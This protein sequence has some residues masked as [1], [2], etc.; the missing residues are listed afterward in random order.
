MPYKP[1]MCTVHANRQSFTAGRS[2]V[3]MELLYSKQWVFLNNALVLCNS[4][5]N[6]PNTRCGSHRKSAPKCHT[7]YSLSH[8]CTTDF[9]CQTAKKSQKEQRRHHRDGDKL[10]VRSQHYYQHR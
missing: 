9:S 5:K 8:A 4:S 1:W 10:F 6:G 7:N 3:P 2:M